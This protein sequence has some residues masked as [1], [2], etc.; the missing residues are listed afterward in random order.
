MK[1][2][3]TKL[4][5]KYT[6]F[7][8]T[9]AEAKALNTFESEAEA[10]AEI[11]SL[12]DKEGIKAFVSDTGAIVYQ[13]NSTKC[14][15]CGG[16]YEEEYVYVPWGVTSLNDAIAAKHAQAEAKE[17]KQLAK[18]F[19]R[20]VENILGNADVKDKKSALAGLADE[21]REKITD[22]VDDVYTDE[23]KAY[24]PK[25]PKPS[26]YLVIG[27]PKDKLTW[28]L[29][30]REDGVTNHRLMGAAWASLHDGYRGSV[31][32]GDGADSALRKLKRL[33]TA[34]GLDYPTSKSLTDD[35]LTNIKSLAADRIGGYAVLWGSESRKDWT[36]EFFDEKTEELTV[37]FDGVGR[38]PLLYQHTLNG[39]IKSAVVGVVDT[40]K[41]DSIGLWYEAEL[42]LANE[43]E[44]AVKKLINGGKLKTSTQTF[45]VAR[46]AEENGHITRWPIVEVSLTPTPAEPRMRA[47]D[48]IK[49]SFAQVGAEN[50]E[51]VMMK[52]GLLP[53]D[54]GEDQGAEKAR[55]V[56]GLEI[57]QAEFL[58][59]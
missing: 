43:Y 20:V 49:S 55:L 35:D 19:E 26:D 31:Y 27:D 7:D 33:Y 3:Y 2:S 32:E 42:K 38:L 10:T 15:K 22:E 14:V 44:T 58:A 53:T 9:H 13:G 21:L 40:L 16:F 56:T 39:A 57:L 29:P 8:T 37:I 36:G 59:L 12:L 1:F 18:M 52:A 54:S 46:K 24:R 11:V 41:A 25:S 4:D 23:A 17:V 5:N 50:I 34:E 6:V 47:V 30:V 48:E 45:N 28:A 51:S